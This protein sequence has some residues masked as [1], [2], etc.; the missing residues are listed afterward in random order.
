MNNPRFYCIAV[1]SLCILQLLIVGC[2]S[3]SPPSKFYTL[4]T[5]QKAATQEPEEKA[6]GRISVK[7][8]P[9][10]IPDYLD[11][12]QIII[13]KG[14]NQLTRA[15]FDRWAGSLR[16]NISTV[17]RENLSVL[18]STDKATVLSWESP[19]PYEYRLAVDIS[20]FEAV[21]GDTVQLEAR[22]TII[23]EKGK[24]V[25]A[26]RGGSFDKKTDG[27]GYTKIVAAMSAVLETLSRQLAKDI[28]A[29]VQ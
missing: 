22:W 20:R 5:L 15:E 28:M 4:T 19:V 6:T 7:L 12:P 29:V 24:T 1:F 3:T 17:L 18:L 13:R 23:E 2:V 26:S 27:H 11:R 14:E 10:D 8:L 9:V 21:A 16:E 25:V